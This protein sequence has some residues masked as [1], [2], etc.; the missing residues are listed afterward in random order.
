M[1]KLFNDMVLP[2]NA[3]L[4]DTKRNATREKLL[5][6]RKLPKLT[7]SATAKK[8]SKHAIPQ[9][10]GTGLGQAEF[11]SNIKIPKFRKS[12]T[13]NMSLKQPVPITASTKPEREDNLKI[14]KL[15][16]IANSKRNRS[17]PEHAMPTV[18]KEEVK[19]TKLRS[20]SVLP[21]LDAAKATNTE[22]KL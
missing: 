21:I 5:R 14:K 16:Q 7:T 13:G 22:P 17:V 11:L 1:A 8:V 15:P 20:D 2:M 3:E 6:G 10:A 19:H 18:N 12:D 4:D 9:V